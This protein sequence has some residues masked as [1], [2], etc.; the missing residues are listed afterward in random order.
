[1][2]SN[3]NSGVRDIVNL[4]QGMEDHRHFIVDDFQR[5]GFENFESGIRF[6]CEKLGVCIEDE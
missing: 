1:M 6:A 3:D 2:S 4:L 5:H